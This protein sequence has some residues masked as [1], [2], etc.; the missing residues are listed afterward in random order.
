MLT[1]VIYDGAC[2]GV[3][4]LRARRPGAGVGALRALRW[5]RWSDHLARSRKKKDAS[6]SAS[7]RH[8]L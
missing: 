5:R 4:A 3:G 7:A 1:Q 8:I 2:G 6:R